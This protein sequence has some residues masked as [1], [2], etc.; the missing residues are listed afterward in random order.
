MRFN[1]FGKRAYII[2]VEKKIQ[3]NSIVAWKSEL[4]NSLQ[5]EFKD[6]IEDVVFS[7]SEITLFFKDIPNGKDKKQIRLWL[8]DFSLKKQNIIRNIWE[9]PVCFDPVFSQDLLF[10]FGNNPI[11]YKAYISDFLKCIFQVNHYG[12]LPGFFYSS[13]LPVKLNLPRKFTPLRLVEPGT[14]A[15]GKSYVGIYPQK[16]P[17]GWHRIGRTYY[18]FFNRLN[19]PPCFALPG[20]KI[21]FNS[22][23]FDEYQNKKIHYANK[24]PKSRSFE[25]I[26]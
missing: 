5:R 16:S 12:F 6:I 4:C 22:I 17:G 13:G 10:Y 18:S 2:N 19:N 8:E 1:T 7:L 26:Y 9:I 21:K 11:A 3:N 25:I 23:S 24:L 15:I 20:D 14:L